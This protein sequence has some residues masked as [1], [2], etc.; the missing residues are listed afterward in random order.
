MDTYLK[1]CSW[2][3]FLLIC[4]DMISEF[5]NLY[6]EWCEAEVEIFN[7]L[8]P[9]NG[10]VIEVGS[11]IGM[12]SVPMS[13]FCSEG[14]L[15]CYEPQRLIFQILCANAALNGWL[16]IF[17]RQCAVGSAAAIIDID[18]GDYDRPWNCDAYSL[19]A[20]FSAEGRY[21]GPVKT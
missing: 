8:L 5:V 7:D 20:G 6:G 12:H 17:A 9:T 15:F 11:N 13:H 3:R 4:G 19:A 16:N 14:K 18:S 10:V 1:A 21:P 2:G